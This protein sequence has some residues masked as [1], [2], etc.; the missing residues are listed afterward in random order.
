MAGWAM[1]R[2]QHL[3]PLDWCLADVHPLPNPPPSNPHPGTEFFRC[4]TSDLKMR[5][6]SRDRH[7]RLARKDILEKKNR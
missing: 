6:A 2:A 1:R 7:W 5:L 4:E 3:V